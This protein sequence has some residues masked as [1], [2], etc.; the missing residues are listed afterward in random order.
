M[1]LAEGRVACAVA[2]DV[3]GRGGAWRCRIHSAGAIDLDS[4]SPGGEGRGACEGRGMRVNTSAISRGRGRR[5]SNRYRGGSQGMERR[6]CF[7]SM[8]SSSAVE[9]ISRS[10]M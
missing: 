8:D 4:F 2:G 3:A 1:S 9:Q 6:R 7:R 5:G 10:S